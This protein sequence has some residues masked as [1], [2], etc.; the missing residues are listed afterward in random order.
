M[1]N[2]PPPLHE[3][4]TSTELAFAYLSGNSEW[5]QI[6][7]TSRKVSV[8][9]VTQVQQTNNSCKVEHKCQHRHTNAQVSSWALINV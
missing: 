4:K 1:C 2:L 6:F 9:V 5:K 3:G 7:P 8:P